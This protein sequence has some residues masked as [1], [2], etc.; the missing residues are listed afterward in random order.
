[1]PTDRGA[2]AV[3]LRHSLSAWLFRDF[4]LSLQLKDAFRPQG[5]TSIFFAFA[6][7][8][9]GKVILSTPCL[10]TASAF[11]AFTCLGS[12]TVLEKLP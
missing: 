10:W 3:T 7:S 5:F 9:L 1:M 8:V 2:F 11:S 6:F 4:T 12:D